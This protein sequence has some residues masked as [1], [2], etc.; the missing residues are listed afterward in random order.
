[1]IGITRSPRFSLADVALY[2]VGVAG[3]AMCLTLIW[4]SMR[5]VMNVGGFC[6]EGG[7]Y[8]IETRCPAGTPLAITFGVFGLFVFGGLA[9]WKGVA[10]GGRYAGLVA[11]AWPALFISLGWN[12]LEFAFNPPGP[13]GQGIVWGWLIPGVVF[14][15]MGAGPLLLALDIG[16][17]GLVGSARTRAAN[18][19]APDDR[20]AL[21]ANRQ[22]LVNDLRAAKEN[23]E[24]AG[25]LVTKLERLSALRDAGDLTSREFEDAKRAILRETR[26]T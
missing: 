24:D 25:D 21:R 7:P 22:Q 9:V 3:L 6:A 2:L 14:I 17:E 19:I 18:R 4:L 15:V 16:K 23:A 8:V 13:P 11:L 10:I 5:A 1:M 26:A 12:F 20:Y